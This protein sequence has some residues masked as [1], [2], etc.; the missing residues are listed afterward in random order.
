MHFRY[1]YDIR[2]RGKEN[3]VVLAVL[4]VRLYPKKSS[5]NLLRD[6]MHRNM[7][8]FVRRGSRPVGRQI[9]E[10]D[11]VSRF[12]RGCRPLGWLIWE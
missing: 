3:L 1:Q 4:A 5:L 11:G 7:Y 6:S 8:A 9:F 2:F 10:S 12:L